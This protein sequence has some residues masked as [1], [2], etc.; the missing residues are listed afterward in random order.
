MSTF[1]G[2][3]MTDILSPPSD[4]AKADAA[5]IGTK[6]RVFTEEVDLETNNVDSG[7]KVAVGRLPANARLLGFIVIANVSL[8]TSQL[9]FGTDSDADAYVA[10]KAY[11]TTAD[12]VVFYADGDNSVNVEVTEETDVYMGVTTDDLPNSAGNAVKVLTVYADLN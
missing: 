10:A 2:T 3:L 5:Q 4:G 9:Q 12:A 6:L 1:N 7:D 11:G 8:G